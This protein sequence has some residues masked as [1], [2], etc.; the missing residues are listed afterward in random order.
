MRLVDTQQLRLVQFPDSALPDYA[1]LS[2]T[3]TTTELQ[4]RDLE[5]I[6]TI[7]SHPGFPKL[8]GACDRASYDGYQ[9]MWVDCCCIDK[10]SSEE[11]STAINTMFRW[12]EK[13]SVCYVLLEDLDVDTATSDLVGFEQCRWYYSLRTFSIVQRPDY[14]SY[15]TSSF[16][17]LVRGGSCHRVTFP[18]RYWPLPIELGPGQVLTP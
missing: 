17:H 12:Y 5:D 16:N 11:L 15:D 2:H 4:Y 6:S 3:W 8:K 10:S 1:I 9:Y 13:S 14:A 18:C 7:R